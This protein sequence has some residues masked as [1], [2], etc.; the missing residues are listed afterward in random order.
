MTTYY[1]Y[2]YCY[3][4]VNSPDAAFAALAGAGVQPRQMLGDPI[5]VAGAVVARGRPG[6][7]TINIIDELTGDP[8]SVPAI[9]DPTKTYLHIR[10][11]APLD[12]DATAY[13]WAESSES[14]SR[15]VLGVWA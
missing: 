6:R 11:T 3:P 4:T 13:G 12:F 14:D 8:V 10:T 5:V 7:A 2:Y 9:G 15:A 1:D